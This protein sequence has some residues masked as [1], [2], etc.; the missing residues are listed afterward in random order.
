[1]IKDKLFDMTSLPLIIFLMSLSGFGII[2][3]LKIDSIF[4]THTR[5]AKQIL[6]K[7]KI[8]DLWTHYEKIG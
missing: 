1:M 6:E 3:S 5:S 4:K 2:F 7:Y 8:S